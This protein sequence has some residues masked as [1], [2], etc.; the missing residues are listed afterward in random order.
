MIREDIFDQMTFKQKCEVTDGVNHED[1]E[2]EV[3][4]AKKVT[5]TVVLTTQGCLVLRSRKDPESLQGKQRN[6]ERGVI[7]WSWVAGHI[8]WGLTDSTDQHR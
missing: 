7:R 3:F 8:R 4:W 6:I 5:S 1:Q 2:G